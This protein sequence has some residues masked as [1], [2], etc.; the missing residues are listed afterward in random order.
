MN[1]WQQNIQI[2]KQ[3]TVADFKLRY[4]GSV[5]GY[6]WSLLKP[7]VFFLVLYIVFG[8]MLKLGGNIEN[9]ASYLLIGIMLW[10]F[11][12]ETTTN[13]MQAVV[14]KSHLIKKIYFPRIIVV[15]VS[16]LNALVNLF[17]NLLVLILLM[18]FFQVDVFQA[19]TFLIVF[20][21]IELW[22]LSFGSALILSVLFVYWRD[23][24]YIWE[25]FLQILFYLTPIIYA[26]SLIP[27]Q[28]LNLVMLNPLAQIITDF[29]AVFLDFSHQPNWYYPWSQFALVL[30]IFV[31]G[32]FLFQTQQ[33]KFAEQI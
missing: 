18:S 29:R 16:S 20:Y 2:I 7:L 22:L 21:I 10:S 3:L 23:F 30:L 9:F 11:F 1:N 13:G 5:L 12:A 19:K 17:F 33:K 6:L 24:N 14:S 27:A 15:I 8:K 31:T 28:Y 25:L 26:L 4:S 32:L